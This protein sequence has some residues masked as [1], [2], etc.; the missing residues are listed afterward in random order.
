[1]SAYDYGLPLFTAYFALVVPVLTFN[2]ALRMIQNLFVS[3][4]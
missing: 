1:M 3:D 4:L 2:F